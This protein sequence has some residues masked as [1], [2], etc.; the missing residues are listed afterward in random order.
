M[1]TESLTGLTYVDPAGRTITV[2]GEDPLLGPS[3]YL[4]ERDDGARWGVSTKRIRDIFWDA[5][6]RNVSAQANQDLG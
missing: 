1:T 6:G 4:V 2:L 3:H 5:G